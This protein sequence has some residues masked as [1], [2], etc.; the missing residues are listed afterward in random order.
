MSYCL[1]P[2]CSQP[3]HPDNLS[4]CP[5]CGTTLLLKNR[6]RSLE[7]LGAGGMGRNYLAV[8]EDT[9]SKRRCVIKQFSP[10]A[11][12]QNDPKIYNKALELFNRE[13]EALDRLGDG[14]P[15]IP[16]LLAYL[17]QEQ[18]LYFLQEY[19]DGNTLNQE[20]KQTGHFSEAKIYQL[21]QQLLAVLRYI[22]KRGV[23][24]RDIKPDNIMRRNEPSPTGAKKGSLV[25]IDFGISKQLTST[26]IAGGT[27][28]G[29]MGYAPPEQLS[30]GEAY[31]ASDLYALAATCVHLLTGVDPSE[32]FD[33]KSK[34]WRWREALQ[35]QG[36]RLSPTLEKT[37]NRML[38]PDIKNRYQ[39]VE[40]VVAALKSKTR[41]KI[42]HK[43]PIPPQHQ[44][45]TL[46]NPQAT[47]VV[48]QP[49]NPPS[50]PSRC[51]RTL[52]GHSGGVRCLA[53]SPDGEYIASGGSDKTIKVWRWQTGEVVYNLE[54][55]QSG[56]LAV[57]FS[58]DG[59]MIAS[60]GGDNAV[61][62][63][64]VE[65]GTEIRTLTGHNDIVSA[66]AFSPDSKTL[67]SGGRDQ[68][69]RLWSLKKGLLQ[70]MTGQKPEVL[71]HHEDMVAALAFHPQGEILASGGCDSMLGLWSLNKS[72]H[73]FC[74][75]LNTEL[76]AIQFDPEGKVI[77]TG[78]SDKTLKLWQAR[79]GRAIRSI[80]GHTKAVNDIA[81][82][83][84]GQKLI[85][86]SSDTTVKLWQTKTGQEI[87]S[88]DEHSS[89]VYAVAF[90]PNGT[91]I[92]SASNDMT[93][94]IWAVGE[95]Q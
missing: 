50:S 31:P 77:A 64:N 95:Q 39:S 74:R 88:Y 15:H 29:T 83:P 21:L 79:T 63:W 40:E 90:H 17:E 67:A 57:T 94:K 82:S 38:E 48:S 32:L 55:H 18:R 93:L 27:T 36:I 53:V 37:L 25:L 87:V 13:A 47:T 35:Q 44:P 9:P 5:T 46:Q 54:G 2:N 6:Y 62:L 26:M 66:I 58:P 73:R 81:F 3:R 14:C 1:N 68:T 51:L 76:L 72:P 65:S 8:D 30:Y 43:S 52:S 42:V 28:A 92:I 71:T 7:F 34:T 75:G 10:S 89:A 60:G 12:I 84:D 69:I 41:A 11:N 91:E 59:A 22:H 23:I 78:N 20:L 33:F 80:V 70:F 16:R 4:Q 86:G 45:T 24:H 56:V 85:S 49:K 61:K 19:I